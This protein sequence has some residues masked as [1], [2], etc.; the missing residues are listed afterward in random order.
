MIFYFDTSALIKL[1]ADELDASV[2]RDAAGNSEFVATSIIAY[3][4]MR[5][6]LARN[7][8]SGEI[9]ADQ[10]VRF[11]LKLE[12]DWSSFEIISIDESVV[13]TAGDFAE[14]YSLRGFD[15][16]HLASAEALRDIFGPITFACFDAE[17]SRAAIACGMSLLPAA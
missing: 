3:T 14:Q 15:A 13:R 17:L 4:E 2:T 1:Y 5:S 12:S 10:L 16:V 9:T 7:R 8:R 11:K 6:A